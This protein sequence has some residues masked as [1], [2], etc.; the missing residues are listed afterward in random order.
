MDGPPS[1]NSVTTFSQTFNIRDPDT[2][3]TLS[4]DTALRAGVVA[5]CG[6]YSVTVTGP[7]GYSQTFNVDP[8]TS[9][10]TE[11]SRELQFE[12]AGSYTITFRETTGTY[13]SGGSTLQ[14]SDGGGAVVDNVSILDC[15]TVDTMIR[16]EYGLCR[17]PSRGWW[18]QPSRCAMTACAPWCSTRD[19]WAAVCPCGR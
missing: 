15:F 8:T 1:A 4:F 17:G 13:Q 19:L 16:T 12:D 7:N 3:A 14:R 18:L 9:T 2:R 5:E 6:K 11:F 10:W